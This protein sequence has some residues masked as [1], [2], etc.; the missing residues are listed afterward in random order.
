M[1]PDKWNN[2]ITAIITLFTQS[3]NDFLIQHVC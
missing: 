2:G 1:I 3:Q